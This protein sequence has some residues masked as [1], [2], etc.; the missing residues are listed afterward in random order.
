[1]LQAT[2]SLLAG[3]WQRALDSLLGLEVWRLVPGD[4]PAQIRAMLQAKVKEEAV[5]VYLLSAGQH[6]SSVSVEHLCQL[7]EADAAYVRQI[8]CRMIFGRELSASFDPSQQMI[9]LRPIEVSPVQQ[10]ALALAEKISAL[11]ESN[12]RLVDPF[13]GVYN[14]APAKD[15]WGRQDK[16]FDST[17][18]RRYAGSRTARPAPARVYQQGFRQKAGSRTSAQ[19][20]S[21]NVWGR[22]PSSTKAK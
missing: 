2:R 5:R 22:Y 15:D 18:R 10:A 14:F 20:G 13:V 19:A 6:Y 12:E 16:K 3:E 17:D 1:V 8:V 21:R 9:S 7:F 11:V 4:G